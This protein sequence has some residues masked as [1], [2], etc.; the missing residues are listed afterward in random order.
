M[1]TYILEF[2]DVDL[3]IPDDQMEYFLNDIQMHSATF[4]IE[5]DDR[6]MILY[7]QRND[8]Q[9]KL[10][11]KKIGEAFKLRCKML[12]FDDQTF[13]ELFQDWVTRLRGHAVMKLVGP[14][15]TVI[16]QI[17]FGEAIRITQVSGHRRKVILD[18]SQSVT[19]ESVIQSLQLHDVEERIPALRAEIDEELSYLAKMIEEKN[20]AEIA[21]SKKRLKDLRR[22]ML[23][24]EI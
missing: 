1:L 3:H 4:N 2:S 21:A 5:D 15:S 18:R 7:I 12:R 13:A 24:L 8:Q 20:E 19:F 23:I 9:L 11:F 16:H 22:E 17:Q 14:D 6:T 10:E